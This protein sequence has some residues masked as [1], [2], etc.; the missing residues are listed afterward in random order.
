M[1]IKILGPGCANCTKL[2]ELVSQAVKDLSI[3]AKL[4]KVT[5][6]PEIMKYTM[7]TPAILVDGTIKH[8]G[9]PLPTMEKIKEILTLSKQ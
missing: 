9:K 8:A 3:D 6:L 2:Y 1:E 4:D 5:E 7:S